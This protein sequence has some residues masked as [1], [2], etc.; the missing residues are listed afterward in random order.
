MKNKKKQLLNTAYNKAFKFRFYPDSEQIVLLDHYFGSA[1]FVF[2]QTL[3]FSINHYNQ[4]QHKTTDDFG[5]LHIIK[6]TEFKSLS[7]TDRIKYIK[8][9]KINNPWLHHVSSIALQQSVINLNNS[10]S[11]FFKKC[12]NPSIKQKGFPQFKKKNNRN[13][14]KIVGKKSIH[15]SEDGSFTLPKFKNPL[16]IRFSRTF[17]RNKVSSVTIS[18]EPNNHY[19][20]SFLSEDNYQRLPSINQK[21]AFDSGIK[22]NITS[23]NG[24]INT[25]GKE[26]FETFN[27]PDLKNLISKIK[28]TQRAFS[29]KVKG[30]NNRNKSRIKLARLY[31]KKE[32]KVND[33]YHKLSTKIVNDNQ[34]IIV[35]D[36][37]LNSMKENKVNHLN[38]NIRKNLQQISLSKIYEY[39]EYKSK[40]YGKTLIYADSY[41]PSSKKCSTLNCDYINHEL[42]L[43]DRTWT[44][45][46]CGK[47]HDR[48]ENAALNLYNYNED[49]AK[50]VIKNVLAYHKQKKSLHKDKDLNKD[51]NNNTV[52]VENRK[53]AKIGLTRNLNL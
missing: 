15:F 30:S 5:D 35:E 38:K 9:L 10:Y 47:V 49:N 2:N 34:V 4:R 48:D 3:N 31:A 39:I 18:K 23:Y 44:C 43:S 29:R 27:L 20:I 33:F 13:S 40:W 16:N 25:K 19:Y 37:N 53:P 21:I 52:L 8:E 46:E 11:N 51:K 6:N 28:L 1:R 45:P 42:S 32:N 7:S 50:I 14:F 26:V 36:L 41:Y 17:N 12:K 22:T 24:N